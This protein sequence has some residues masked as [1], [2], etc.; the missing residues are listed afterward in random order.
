MCG[1][2]GL[3]DPRRGATGVGGLR[4]RPPI[5][6]ASVGRARGGPDELRG[7]LGS[8]PEGPPDELRGPPTRD[9][10]GEVNNELLPALLKGRGGRSDSR[11]DGASMARPFHSS[12]F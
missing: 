10:E 7:P 9:E 3:L 5:T 1:I 6:S 2:A 8:N 4:D 12:C 11:G